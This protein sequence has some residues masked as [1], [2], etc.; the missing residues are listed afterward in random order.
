MIGNKYGVG[1]KWKWTKKFKPWKY[2]IEEGEKAVKFD[3]TTF[4][5]NFA[6]WKIFL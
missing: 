1:I 5:N 4:H 6:R 3:F 2:E